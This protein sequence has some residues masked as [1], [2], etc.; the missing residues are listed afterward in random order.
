MK[1]I[2]AIALAIM[3]LMLAIPMSVM[4]AGTDI[5]VNGTKYSVTPLKLDATKLAAANCH[6]SWRSD[7]AAGTLTVELAENSASKLKLVRTMPE[8]DINIKGAQVGNFE[9]YFDLGEKVTVENNLFFIVWADFGGIEFRKGCFGFTTEDGT[10]YTTDDLDKKNTFY[11]LADGATEWTALTYGG[12][13]CFGE[14]D[15]ANTKNQKGYFAFSLSDFVTS[16]K[17]AL[18]SDSVITGFYMFGSIGKNKDATLAN[19]GIPFYLDN[20]MFAKDAVTYETIASGTRLNYSA[21]D[22]ADAQARTKHWNQGALNG[23]IDVKIVDGKGVNGSD[24]IEIVRHYT[25]N[26]GRFEFI[27]NFENTGYLGDNK[28]LVVWADFTNIDFAKACFGLATDGNVT[29]AYRTDDKAGA[30]DLPFYYLADG[31]TDWEVFDHGNDECFGSAQDSSI[32]GKKGYFAFPVAD[33]VM[34]EQAKTPLT[35]DSNITGVY[36]FA[37]TDV[38]HGIAFYLDDIQ[39]IDDYKNVKAP[40]IE[41]PDPPVDPAPTGDMTIALVTVAL[42]S[43]AAVTVIAKKKVNE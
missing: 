42:V 37:N 5:D 14:T 33:F 43:L 35:S 27:L 13:G 29:Q 21:E 22:V 34:G 26:Q 12:D 23:T 36:L 2:V 32:K 8:S 6:A 18:K 38:N 39:L 41:T 3:M 24:A 30:A 19:S 1:K 11:Y 25:G 9:L 15:E 20:M 4:A 28:Y 16:G 17:A 40:E 10:L 31:A 7:P